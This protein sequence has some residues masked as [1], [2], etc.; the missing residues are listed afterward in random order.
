MD[1]T[2]TDEQRAVRDLARRFAES[3]IKPMAQELDARREHPAAVVKQLGELKMMGVAVPEEYGGW[4]K[5]NVGYVLVLMEISKACASTGAIMFAH[6]SLYCAPVLS[7]GND[8]QKAEYLAPCASGRK[9]GCFAYTEDDAGSDPAG[10]STTAVSKDDGWLVNGK[11]RFITNGNVSSYCLLVANAEGK[12]GEVGLSLLLVSLEDTPGFR[13]GRVEEKL[14]LL[15]T[16][17]AEMVFKDVRVPEE[18]LLGGPGSGLKQLAETLARGHIGVAAQ[19]VGLGR[20]V[21]EEAVDYAAKRRQFGKPISAFQPI[22]WKLADMAVELDAAELLTL[23]AAWLQDHRKAYEKEAAM[24]KVFASDAA[25][26]ASIEGVQ[27]LG[28]YGYL[29]ENAMERHMRDAKIYQ[30]Y[31]STNEMTRLSVAKGL[32]MG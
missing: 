12:K 11:K 29:K 15:A 22:Q 31:Q 25:M 7:F 13:V 6:N 10:V 1:F 23:R 9:V 24:A 28:A 21:L 14:G 27:V 19:A 30:I 5:D 17:T 32:L 26:K 20:T 16:G 18:A 8:P 3:E 4:G 2:L